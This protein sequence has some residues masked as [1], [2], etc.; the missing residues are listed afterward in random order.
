MRRKTCTPLFMALFMGD[1][2]F[3]QGLVAVFYLAELHSSLTDPP[4]QAELLFLAKLH[5]SAQ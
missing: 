1:V 4:V 5:W 3:L 2:Q